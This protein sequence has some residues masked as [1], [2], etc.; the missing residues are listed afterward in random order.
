[1]NVLFVMRGSFNMNPH[2]RRI[3]CNAER[4]SLAIRWASS[5]KLPING[6]IVN[7]EP[8]SGAGAPYVPQRSFK[9]VDICEDC[10]GE[11]V[12]FDF[13]AQELP[14]CGERVVV[15]LSV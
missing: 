5:S 2:W 1:M 12:R 8:A 15:S 6:D 3:S 14:S 10:W 11:R 13:T 4:E 7:G 9:A